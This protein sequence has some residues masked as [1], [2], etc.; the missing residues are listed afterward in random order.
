[1]GV[2][3]LVLIDYL[4][5]FGTETRAT[6]REQVV[7]IVSHTLQALQREFGFTMLVAAQL[8]S[9][10]IDKMREARRDESGKLI[11]P[12]PNE[13]D[14]RESRAMYHDADRVIFLYKPPF[15]CR[16]VDQRSPGVIKPEVWLYQEKRRSGGV[17]YVRCWFEKR[18]TR[19][20]EV[21]RGEAIAADIAENS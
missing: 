6:N 20:V 4:Q 13:G 2:P 21:E 17:T 5:L 1:H 19:F 3:D 15:D 16:D 14:L 8:N 9:S 10:G 7:A 11:H 12:L 18:Y